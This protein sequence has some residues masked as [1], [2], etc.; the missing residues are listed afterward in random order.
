[1]LN[2]DWIG[3]TESET[4]GRLG[5]WK[6]CERNEMSDVCIGKLEDVLEMPTMSSQV[7]FIE[8]Q[9]FI[10]K[11]ILK[12]KLLIVGHNFCWYIGCDIITHHIVFSFYDFSQ[13]NY[14]LSSMWMDANSIR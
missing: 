11:L 9:Y 14:S 8:S 1:M 13:V 2:K 12:K 4:G 10:R 5:L 6:I 7:S 3:D